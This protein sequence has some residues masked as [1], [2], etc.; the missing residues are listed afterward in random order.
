MG[1]LILCLW[2]RVGLEA[3][4]DESALLGRP[5][6]LFRAA[7]GGHRLSFLGVFVEVKAHQLDSQQDAR[8]EED[9]YECDGDERTI[10]LVKS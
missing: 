7:V 9:R 1:N 8:K 5:I 2:F 3:A 10:N 6:Q 4:V